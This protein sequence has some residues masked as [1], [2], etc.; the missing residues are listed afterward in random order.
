[1]EKQTDTLYLRVLQKDRDLQLK[2]GKAKDDKEAE[3]RHL[4]EE[5]SKIEPRELL[6]DT[7]RQIIHENRKEGMPVHGKPKMKTSARK[8]KGKGKQS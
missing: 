5:A 3:G 2:E 8:G 4:A 6:K 7:I 1:M